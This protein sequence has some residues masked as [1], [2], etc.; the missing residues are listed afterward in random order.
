M[1]YRSVNIRSI[2]FCSISKDKNIRI[3][4]LQD[5]TCKQNIRGRFIDLGRLDITAVYVCERSA[6]LVVATN[7]IGIFQPQHANVAAY[8]QRQPTSHTKPVVQVLYN[9]VFNVVSCPLRS[10]ESIQLHWIVV[11]VDLAF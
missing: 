3:W 11:V 2:A 9:P 10:K 4:D 8:R 5:Y 1:H 7:Q 6:Q